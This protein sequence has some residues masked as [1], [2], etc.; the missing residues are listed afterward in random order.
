M[1]ELD[2]S[3]IDVSVQN[4]IRSLNETIESADLVV[5]SDFNYG[6]LSYDLVK[7]IK[8]LCSKFKFRL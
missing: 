5:L 2:E 1:S 8:D 6:V 4:S 3:D 7:R